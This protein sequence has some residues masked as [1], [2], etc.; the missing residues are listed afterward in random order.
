MTTDTKGTGII[1][2]VITLA[3]IIAACLLLYAFA[4]L[5]SGTSPRAIVYG[6]K[7]AMVLLSVSIIITTF[8]IPSV[9]HKRKMKDGEVIKRNIEAVALE[10]FI[11]V[12]IC[13]LMT[14]SGN[15]VIFGVQYGVLL[16]IVTMAMRV[17]ERNILNYFRSKGRNS[18]KILFLGSDPANLAVYNELISDPSTGYKVMGYYSDGVLEDAPEKLLKLGSKDDFKHYM[19][20]AEDPI[21]EIEEIYC[22]LSHSESEY[23]QEVMQFCDKNVI[24]FYY[25]PRIFGN[26]QLSLH[27]EIFGSMVIYTNHHEPLNN[28]NNRIVKRLFDIVVSA[29][30]LIFM[31]PFLP[32]IALIIKIQSPGPLI[33]KQERTG[34]NGDTFTCYKFRSMHVNSN[35][36]TLQATKNDPRKFAFGN[37]MRK[38]NIDEFPQFFNVLIGDMSIVGPRP[39]M[40]F[41]TEK[42]S[43][44]IGK[45]MVR[46]F[47]K[48]GITGYA[49][50]TGFRGETEQLWQMEG[51][52]KKDIWYIENWSMWL[53]L[54]I[55]ALTAWSI[56]HPDKA[57]Y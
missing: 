2:W 34:F 51:R 55:I 22:S 13:R 35:A 53:D 37:F 42:Y 45:Y 29:I 44:L 48:P 25:V 14:T 33:F 28:V 15:Y 50:V 20:T 43:Q 31:L 26:I 36:D 1:G 38:T 27:P 19:E 5:F 32:I 10:V 54:K 7:S 21:S 30:V 52:V 49:Q 40:V 4:H 6:T 56:I 3:D 8:I 11:F 41:H 23:I 9:I 16:F 57:A 46:H 47:S 24:H 39:H 12:L 17:C 18:R